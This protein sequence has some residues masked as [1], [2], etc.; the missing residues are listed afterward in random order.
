MQVNP[1]QAKSAPALHSTAQPPLPGDPKPKEKIEKEPNATH[2]AFK[3]DSTHV[4]PQKGKAQPTVE[5]VQLTAVDL[6]SS[7]LNDSNFLVKDEDDLGMTTSYTAHIKASFA[8]PNGSQT[9]VVFNNRSALHTQFLAKEKALTHQSTLTTNEFEVGVRNNHWLLHNPRFSTG[10]Q[11]QYKGIDTDPHSGWANVQADLHQMGNLRQYQ[12]HANPFVGNQA[13]LT[14]MATLDF[15]D[16]K[17]H[18]KMYLKTEGHTALG[19]MIPL[20]Q[21]RDFYTPLRADASGSVKFGYAYQDRPL[22]YLKLDGQLSN[23]PLPY[24]RDHGTLGSV[25]LALGNEFR[26]MQRKNMDVNLFLETKVIQPYGNLGH[27]PLP[28]QSGKHD[29][30]HQMVNFKLQFKLK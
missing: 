1:H 26:L 29:L 18:G 20:Q 15:A 4:T 17:I 24:D 11:L 10:A 2:Q 9:D 19:T 14:P 7:I 16:E 23:D 30:I 5:L 12:N 27:N 25:G 13:Y 21:N 22:I 6:G 8:H 28:D 3:P